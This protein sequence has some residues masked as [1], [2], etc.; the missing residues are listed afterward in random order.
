MITWFKNLFRPYVELKKAIINLKS[1]TVFRGVVYAHRG[2][3][4]ELR[5][6]EII[7]DRGQDLKGPKVV[8]GQVLVGVYEIDFIQVVS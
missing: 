5:N 6:V 1:G 2:P 7:E 8:D 4:I 3:W